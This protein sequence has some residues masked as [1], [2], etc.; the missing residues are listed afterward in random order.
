MDVAENGLATFLFYLQL[1]GHVLYP[2]KK[3]GGVEGGA[4][5]ILSH[6]SGR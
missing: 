2:P 5:K 1:L 6:A 4:F 3:K